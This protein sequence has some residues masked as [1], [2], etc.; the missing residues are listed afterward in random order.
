[1]RTGEQFG[2]EIQRGVAYLKSQ[3]ASNLAFN[4]GNYFYGN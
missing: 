1:M 4:Q 2:D 3:T